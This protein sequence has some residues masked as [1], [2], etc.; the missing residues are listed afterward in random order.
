M[1]KGNEHRLAE[2]SNPISRRKW[3]TEL[4]VENI[5]RELGKKD[6]AGAKTNSNI[7]D[8]VQL[9]NNLKGKI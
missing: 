4:A 9:R 8:T 2:Q 7:G 6:Q 3:M 5:M 1:F